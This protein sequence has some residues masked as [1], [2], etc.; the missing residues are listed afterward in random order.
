M[1]Y[2]VIVNREVRDIGYRK[3]ENE[4]YAVY[5][6]EEYIGQVFELRRQHWAA[7]PRTPHK[8]SPLYG[9]GSRPSAMEIILRIEGFHP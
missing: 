1:P 4:G 6:G 7:V 5:L 9:F 3:L 2:S 8:L